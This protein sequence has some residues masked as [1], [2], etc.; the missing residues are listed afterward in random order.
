MKINLDWVGIKYIVYIVNHEG[1]LVMI[2]LCF[3]FFLLDC[4]SVIRTDLFTSSLRTNCMPFAVK[5]ILNLINP[6]QPK[7][8]LNNQSRNILDALQN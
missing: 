1:G 7:D 6:N 4:V 8:R 2:W 5:Y 3:F